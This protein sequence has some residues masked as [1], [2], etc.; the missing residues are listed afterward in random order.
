MKEPEAFTVTQINRYIKDLFENDALL[1]EIKVEGELSNFKMHSSG[2]M[3]FTLKDATAAINCIMFASYSMGLT[4]EPENGSKV[5]VMG[6]VSIYEKTGQYQLYAANMKPMG[7]GDLAAA[8]V[9][10]YNSL[11]AEGLF[12]AE[13]KKSIPE[14]V[15]CIALVTSPTGA[16]VADM[17]K[18]IKER[19]IGVKIAIM[20]TLVQGENAALDIVNSIQTVNEWGKA[21]VIIVGRGGGSMEDLWAFNEEIV[22]RA[23]AASGIPVISAVGHEVDFTIAD[24]VADLRAPTPSAAAV[25]AVTD[26][27]EH[28]NKAASLRQRADWA[29]E[30]ALTKAR[31]D[32][33]NSKNLLEKL[34][35]YALWERGYAAVFSDDGTRIRSV[36]GLNIDDIVKIYM[37]DG[38]AKCA[39]NE[40]NKRK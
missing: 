2:H 13:R 7:E 30:Q 19:N 35:P 3:Y 20:P 29:I 26:I 23:I 16:V 31:M 18:I 33:R 40:I 25:A 17:I 9:R 14:F 36:E 11:E 32:L 27:S 15:N 8:F 6:H 21:D 38:E 10:L 34:S 4:F 22:A 37:Q 39:I 5:I 28:F 12:K 1:Y 24:F